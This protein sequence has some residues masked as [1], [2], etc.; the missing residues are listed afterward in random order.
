MKNLVTLAVSLIASA[1]IAANDPACAGKN[2]DVCD[3]L[4]VMLLAKGKPCKTMYS[5]TPVS[6]RDGG[7]T[8]R[9]VCQETSATNK[10][11]TYILAFGPGNR[12]YNVY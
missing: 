4:G 6:S 7:D 5:V 10:R 3:G 12:T 2:Q 1:A 9:I 11:V 8:Y